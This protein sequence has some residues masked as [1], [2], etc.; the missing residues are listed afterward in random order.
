[1]STP[2]PVVD[3]WHLD[4]AAHQITRGDVIRRVEPKVMQVLTLLAERPGVVVSRVCLLDTVWGGAFVGDD[5]VSAAIIKLRRAFG[6]NARSPRVIE[7]VHRSGYRLIASVV[8]D[9]VAPRH[10]GAMQ[11]DAEIPSTVKV[12]TLMRCSFRIEPATSTPMTPEDWRWATDTVAGLIDDAIRRHLGEP[13]R[14]SGATIGVFGAPV[15]EEHHAIRA[16]Q[17]AMEIREEAI[18]TLAS[19]LDRFRCSWHIALASGQILS[20]PTVVGG[21]R[22]V[23]GAPLQRV[24]SLGAVALPGE[25]LLAG[26][27]CELAWGLLGVQ[28]CEPRPHAVGVGDFYCIDDDARWSTRWQ[29]RMERGLTPLFGRDHE[30]GRIDDLLG[31]AIRGEG[32][33]IAISG[34]PGAG[35]SRLVH[36]SLLRAATLGFDTFVAAASPLEARTPFFPLRDVLMDRLRLSPGVPTDEATL[37]S[38]LEQLET[39]RLLDVPA[40]LAALR[41]GR[42]TDDWTT[43]DPEVRRSRSMR[44]LLDV[45]ID[46]ERP[47]LVVFEDL[48]WADQ[49]TVQLVDALV[50]QIARRPCVSMITYRPEFIDPWATKSYYTGLRIDPLSSLDS[51]RMIDHLVGS[52]PSLERWKSAVVV[53]AGGTPLFI[54][55]VVRSARLVGTLTGETGAL[56]LAD[57]S[58]PGDVPASVHALLAD[59]IGRLSASAGDILSLAAVI[60]RDVPASL[61]DSL[62]AGTLADRSEDIDE[63]QAAELLFG[64]RFQRQTGYVFKHALTQ[65]VA[66][67]E[68]PRLLR[69][70]HHRRVADLLETSIAGGG[71]VS[72]ELLARHHSGAEQ[73]QDAIHAWIRAAE[74]A[75]NAAAFADALDHLE[76]ARSLL[77]HATTRERDG[78]ELTIELAA[79]SALIQS[80]GPADQAVKDAYRQAR[81]LADSSGTAQQRFEAGWGLWFVHLMQGQINTAQQLGDELFELATG[82]NDPAL[83]LEAHH[84]QWAGLSLAGDP[85][86]V[87]HHTEI[88]IEQYR[89]D[90][91]HWLTFSY[92]GH[93]PGVCARNLDAMAHWLLGEP[94]TARQRSASALSLADDLAHGYT[95]LESF[96]S[97]LNIALLDGDAPALLSLTSV[98]YALVN[99]GTLPEVASSYADGFRAGALVLEGNLEAGLALM[100]SAGPV[101]REFWGAWC[102]PLESA[103]ATMLALAGNTAEAIDHVEARLDLADESGSHWWDPEFHRVLGE[104]VWA[105]DANDV[106]RAE[107]SIRRA[108]D[109]ARRQRA[110]FFELRAAT[111]LARLYRDTARRDE[112]LELLDDACNDFPIDAEMTDL[113]IARTLRDELTRT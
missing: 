58:S 51:A 22:K 94:N 48:Q 89:R 91:H 32:R 72:P 21:G 18:T 95:R 66:Y 34:E 104:L 25:I 6:D 38:H 1:M 14:E 78:L 59:R 57:P 53:R 52:D 75:N 86:S 50:A 13:I 112:A 37:Q 103:F 10:P 39:T 113:A 67:S 47:S 73:Y 44:A 68:I 3:G 62:I 63:L 4:V 40:L 93:D 76:Q 15:A 11:L 102:F 98:L 107:V 88:G 105:N 33:V 71:L 85:A 23:H 43:I 41:P 92:G 49:A 8:T 20:S 5:A 65:Q 69:R 97:A 29:A 101:W 106:S 12:A 56:E 45:L 17:A 99:D 54:E 110:R 55:E 28:V 16:V 36:E 60:G 61:L 109:E 2:D 42:V 77:T 26:E 30:I 83:K 70:E 31:N 84:V 111:S 19:A 82:L 35:K 24:I 81:R 100:R 46:D 27:T 64:S 79:A 90:E 87:R 9:E 7:T 96:N 74:A 80:I 108:I